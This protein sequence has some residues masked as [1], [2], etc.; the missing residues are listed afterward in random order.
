MV[1]VGEV[2]KPEDAVFVDLDGDGALDV[3]SSTEGK[4][5]TIFVHW[6]P[7]SRNHYLDAEV[8]NASAIV[9]SKSLTQWMFT[10]PIQSD[11]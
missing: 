3:V 11:G 8:W 4:T 1:T 5:R 2:G 9:A 6:A 7:Q 10:L